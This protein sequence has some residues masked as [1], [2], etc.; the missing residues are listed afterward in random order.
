M[1]EKLY[2]SKC[3]SP[4]SEMLGIARLVALYY[5]GARDPN[6]S[7]ADFIIGGSIQVM[8]QRDMKLYHLICYSSRHY[9]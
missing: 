4:L 5:I 3:K 8:I 2:R 1:R 9:P 6:E 7:L